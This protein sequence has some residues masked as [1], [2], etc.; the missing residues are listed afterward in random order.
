MVLKILLR[1]LITL[2]IIVFEEHLVKHALIWGPFLERPGNLSGPK[3]NF[4]IKTCLIVVAQF[5][6]NKAASLALLLFWVTDSFIVSISKLMK[7]WSWMQRR[8]T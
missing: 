6:A 4:E 2:F 5:L 1:E 3:A 8:Q 7:L